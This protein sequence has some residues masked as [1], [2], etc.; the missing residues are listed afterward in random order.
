MQKYLGMFSLAFAFLLLP[1]TQSFAETYK[2]GPASHIKIDVYHPAKHVKAHNK[3]GS[4]KGSFTIKG[5][6]EAGKAVA[7]EGKIEMKVGDLVSGN[8]RRD[9]YMRR[10]LGGS[11]KAI[12]FEPSSMTLAKLGANGGEG[13]IKG[14]FTIHGVTQDVTFKAMFKGNLKGAKFAVMIKA[15][16]LCSAYKIKRPSL[17]FVKIKDKVDLAMDIHFVK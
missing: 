4:V 5:A 3:P 2:A 10:S 9:K 13:E 14:K 12:S 8:G 11:S 17:M 16:V 15:S 1:A 7:L 6:V